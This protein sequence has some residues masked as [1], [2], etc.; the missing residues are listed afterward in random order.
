[1]QDQVA[2]KTSDRTVPEGMLQLWP[3]FTDH[4]RAAVLRV[5]DS[6]VMSGPNA[7][8]V[9]ALEKEFGDFVGAKHCLTTNSGT[10]ALHIAV[11]AAGIQPGDEVITSAFTFLAS[12]LAVLHHNAIPVFADIDPVTFNIDPAEIERRITP[13]T[14][15]IIP[16][17]I[18][19]LPADM[20]EIMSIAR[21]HNLVVI[22]DAA[23]AHGATYKGK[24]AG[25]IGDMGAFSI[26]SSKN[27]SA[28]EGGLF[29]TDNDGFHHRAD[30][31]RQFGEEAA[32]TSLASVDPD[33]PLD[34]LRDYNAVTMGWMYRM[35]SLTAAIAR[36]QLARLPDFNRNA[37]QNAE[38]LSK[39]L[40]KLDLV[41]PPSIPSDR[42]TVSHKYRVRL[43]PERLE[44]GL[45]PKK[46]RNAVMTA[47]RREGV[48]VVLWQVT[49]VPSQIL[50][51]QQQGYGGGCPWTCHKSSVRYQ[52]E[53]YPRTRELLDNSIVIGS[54]S[55]PL[56]AQ[57]LE[58]MHY[59]GDAFEKVFAD[60]D[61][62][63]RLSRSAS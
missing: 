55:A 63:V 14:R 38:Y 24:R 18:H 19:G 23:Q 49:P 16:V 46:F 42:T 44:A 8:E 3:Q 7:P 43:H 4:E 17:H 28:G 53:D 36:C 58:L 2:V 54:Q 41:S 1:M 57:N 20:D 60:K 37:V 27:L 9:K 6:R 25:T 26:Q 29:V 51:Q 61:T 21:K 40:S 59:Y 30:C 32:D 13:R 34:D 31:V 52:N 50:F 33:R 11:A 45:D 62:L 12:A 15:A 48:E 10:S 47:L 35:T 56:A 5:L 22:E 39:R